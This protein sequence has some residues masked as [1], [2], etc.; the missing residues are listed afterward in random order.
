MIIVAP[1]L[2][3]EK[4]IAFTLYPFIFVRDKE[5][6]PSVINHEKI[7]LAQQLEMILTSL[8]FC[9]ITMFIH[10]LGLIYYILFSYAFFFIW[11]Y[12]EYFIRGVHL[13][14]FPDAYYRI[15][16]ERE[17]YENENN[18]LYLKSR[19]VWAFLKYL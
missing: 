9:F 11:Y 4:T 15:S 16:F 19:S 18:H 6:Q 14:S 1:W 2:L 5:L 12:I 3:P 17:A 8:I 10:R 7:H 13:K